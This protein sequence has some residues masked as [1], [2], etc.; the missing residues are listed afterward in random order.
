MIK[1]LSKKL[2]ILL[3]ISVMVL[4]SVTMVSA[5][6]S[7]WLDSPATTAGEWDTGDIYACYAAASTATGALTYTYFRSLGTLQ[8]SFVSSNSRT[9]EIELKE[10]DTI[11]NSNDLVKTYKGTFSGRA[12]SSITL[13]STEISGNIESSGDNCA[14]LYLKFKVGT[15]NNDPSDP[16]IATG[17]FEYTVGTN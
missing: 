9:L 17:L 8:S 6:G 4:S 15:V 14:E 2:I 16:T 7:P 10:D 1:T 13:N 11:F 5:T 12:L 3:C